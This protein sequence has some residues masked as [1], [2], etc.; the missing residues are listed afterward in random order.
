MVWLEECGPRLSPVVVDRTTRPVSLPPTPESMALEDVFTLGSP[1]NRS[2][3]FTHISAVCGSV[4][5]LLPP[6]WG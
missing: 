6:S 4:I 1:G 3:W 2:K 5:Y